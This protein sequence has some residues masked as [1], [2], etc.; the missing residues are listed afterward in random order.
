MGFSSAITRKKKKEREQRKER[1]E[2][3]L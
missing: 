2:I 3:H 1:R